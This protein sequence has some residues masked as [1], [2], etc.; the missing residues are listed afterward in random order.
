M[1]SPAIFLPFGLVGLTRFQ[2]KLVSTVILS[3][4]HVTT[5]RIMKAYQYAYGERGGVVG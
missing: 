5:Y 2:K 3:L 1:T 4:I